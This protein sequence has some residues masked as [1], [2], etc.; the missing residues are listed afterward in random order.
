M[1]KTENRV[2]WYSAVLISLMMSSPRLLALRE[3]GII[4]H[5]WHFNLPE[6]V[7]QVICNL[8]FCLL[9]F[10]ANLP[11]HKWFSKY[12]A[13]KK[14]LVYAILNSLF[15]LACCLIAGISQR[16]LF[17]N[18]QIRQI[19][20]AGCFSRF[21]LSAVLC[22]I[23]I[24][25][26]LLLRESKQKDRD[27]DSLRVAYLEAELELLKEQLDP[28]FLFNSLSTLSGMVRENPVLAQQF[29]NQL[30]K[31]FR[32]TLSHSGNQMATIA[33]ELKMIESYSQLLKMRFEDAFRMDIRV[34][35]KY[36]N[37]KI[38]HLSLQ[39]LLE[40]AARHNAVTL[41][42]PLTV[43]IDIAN[44][45]L[46]IINNLQQITPE[47]STGIGLNNLSSR[48]R[49]LMQQEIVIEKNTFQFIVKLPINI[50]DAVTRNI[51]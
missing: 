34:A 9:L 4:A 46:R 40:N 48:Y 51:S 7:F 26:I 27:H 18:L 38:P 17:G 10:Y 21:F 1:D 39:P 19:Y 12:R 30:S 23:M 42:K 36:L 20:W 13:Q 25:I 2:C 43:K 6:V 24:K 44:G 45:Y 8:V 3:N 15:I 37:L 29:I 32:Y 35:D 33:D 11:P 14:Y 22:G 5:Y 28:H 49:I 16:H 50:A 47:H 31:I 41:V